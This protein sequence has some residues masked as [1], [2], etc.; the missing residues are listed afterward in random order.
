MALYKLYDPGGIVINIDGYE[1]QYLGTGWNAAYSKQKF[2]VKTDNYEQDLSIRLF[3]EVLAEGYY[4]ST[5]LEGV[6]MDTSADH[7]SLT[8]TIRPVSYQDG[9]QN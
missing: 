4:F 3:T 7:G 1:F 5:A 2:L 9:G 6:W 8:K